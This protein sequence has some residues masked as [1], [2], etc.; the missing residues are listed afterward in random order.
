[1]INYWSFFIHFLSFNFDRKAIPLLHTN[2]SELFYWKIGYF[3]YKNTNSSLGAIG[4]GKIAY[5]TQLW[6]FK[7]RKKFTFFVIGKLSR[8]SISWNFR[9]IKSIKFGF[10]IIQKIDHFFDHFFN[11]IIFKK[12]C[13]VLKIYDHIFFQKVTF[14][15]FHFNRFFFFKKSLSEI[16]KKLLRKVRIFFCRKHKSCDRRFTFF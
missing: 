8:D 15:I 11:L 6:I 2:Y 1:M 14:F 4:R 7:K 10:K 5:T 16:K 9:N 12:F 3:W 13:K